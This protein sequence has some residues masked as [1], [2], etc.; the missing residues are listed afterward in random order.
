MKLQNLMRQ[1]R[2]SIT[3]YMNR[4]AS[5]LRSMDQ[6]TFTKDGYNLAEELTMYE[7]EML[8]EYIYCTAFDEM[9]KT[10]GRHCLNKCNFGSDSEDF[11]SNFQLVII[12]RLKEFNLEGRVKV[13]GKQYE[14]GT[15]LKHLSGEAVRVTFA[16]MRGVSADLEE[17][18]H[19]VY[20]A[21]SKIAV[22]KQIK[23]DEVTAEM[24]QEEV[25]FVATVETIRAIMEFSSTRSSVEIMME[26][27]DSVE[28][29]RDV[30]TDVFDVLERDT[31]TI[32]DKFFDRL[33]DFEK[34]FV[35]IKS[36][37]VPSSIKEMTQ[38]Q[39]S[40]DEMLINI[41]KQDSK[42]AKNV[43]IGDVT[44]TRWNRSSNSEAQIFKDV[45]YVKDRVITYQ[46]LKAQDLLARLG[47]ALD[48]N[49]LRGMCGVRYFASQWIMLKEKYSK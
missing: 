47:E 49:E 40:M 30:K 45:A 29:N 31:E 43:F 33:S 18:F 13:E 5:Y 1:D 48:E 3:D 17:R 26:E 32:L 34:F 16:Q 42:N 9:K 4:A 8:K 14:F 35:L 23:H 10:V 24:I 44:V 22:E 27:N 38:A 6:G 21:I 36:E 11:I 2:E 41:A 46:M 15:F 7:Q 19:K 12:N 39:L 37:C 25:S 28:G 20:A